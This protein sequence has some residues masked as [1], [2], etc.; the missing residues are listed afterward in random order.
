MTPILDYLVKGKLPEDPVDARTLM[1]KIKN[2]TIEDGV[3][4][5]KSYLVPLMRCVGPLQANYIIREVHMGSCGMHDGPRQVVAKAMS[6]G[7]LWPSMHRD[8]RELIRVCDDCQAHAAVPRLPKADMISVTSAWPFMKF[9]IPATI[10]TDN[11]TYFMN[12][13]FKKWAEKLMIKLICT[14]VYHPQGNEAVERANK[15]LLR[16]IKTRLEKG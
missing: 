1:E 10:V 6:L 4:Y 8:A 14:L 16:G 12:D 13:P 11:G 9:R 7:Y 5:R 15:S 2:Y 3:L